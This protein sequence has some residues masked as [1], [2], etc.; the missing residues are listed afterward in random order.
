MEQSDVAQYESNSVE[1]IQEEI[2]TDKVVEEAKK[3][4]PDPTA[5]PLK[6]L[7]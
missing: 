1:L 7:T 5:V 3:E 6:R 2:L 4:V